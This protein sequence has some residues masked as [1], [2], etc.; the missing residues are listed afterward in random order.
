MSETIR[1]LTEALSFTSLQ[2]KLNKLNDEYLVISYFLI[3]RNSYL[4]SASILNNLSF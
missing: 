4:L 3:T 1:R 2:E